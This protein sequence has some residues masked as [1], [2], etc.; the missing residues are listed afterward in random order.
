MQQGFARDLSTGRS[1]PV[2]E[3]R[4]PKRLPSLSLAR[5][6]SRSGGAGSLPASGA[7]SAPSPTRRPTRRRPALARH[8]RAAVVGVTSRADA[9][10]QG[11]ATP[12]APSA[13][14]LTADPAHNR[15]PSAGPGAAR[16]ADT[17]ASSTA[18]SLASAPGTTN[19]LPPTAPV[20]A[21]AL[22]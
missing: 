10:P 1:G 2:A 9:S 14:G 12:S 20:R 13:S 5:G 3:P 15:L 22:A 4:F 16:L 6:A 18:L 7:P 19:H 21:G 8:S 11:A 17:P